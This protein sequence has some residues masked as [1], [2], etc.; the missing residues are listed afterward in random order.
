MNREI[1]EKLRNK[2]LELQEQDVFIK[3]ENAIQYYTTI[4]SAQIIISDQKLIISDSK[5]QDLIV[6]LYYVEDVKVDGNT[7]FLELSNDLNITLD[8]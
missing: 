8:Y 6:E 7:I 3:I 1:I 2:I 4:K 5:Q